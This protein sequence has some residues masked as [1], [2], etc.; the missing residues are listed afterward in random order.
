MALNVAILPV[1][2]KDLPISPRC[3]GGRSALP[4]F[5]FLFP[6]F[7]RPRAGGIGHR[8]KNTV[9]FFGLATNTLNVRN[10][11]MPSDFFIAVQVQPLTT[12]QQM[13]EFYLTRVLTLS[14]KD[15]RIKI[16]LDKYRTHDF[17]TTTSRYADYLLDH[18]RV[19]GYLCTNNK[20]FSMFLPNRT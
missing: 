4:D 2:T 15:A 19:E 16:L 3:G 14:A 7:S 1:D 20:W 8:V 10:I 11:N 18:S 13:V 17:R 12:F 6:R 5:F 9:V